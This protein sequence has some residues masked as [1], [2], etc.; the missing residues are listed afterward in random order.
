MSNLDI[1]AQIEAVAAH[2]QAKQSSP[3][4]LGQEVN[5]DLIYNQAIQFGQSVHWE[6][7]RKGLSHAQ[8][9]LG[10]LEAVVVCSRHSCGMSH[11]EARLARLVDPSFLAHL[12]NGTLSL[13]QSLTLLTSTQGLFIVKGLGYSDSEITSAKMER[14]LLQRGDWWV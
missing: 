14:F 7:C 12:E 5:V 9:H 4:I 11:E 10:V 3:S 13:V 1:I 2:A 6:R 8:H